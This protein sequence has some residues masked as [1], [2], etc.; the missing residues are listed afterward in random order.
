[1]L[2]QQNST[3]GEQPR[4][5]V[6]LGDMNDTLRQLARMRGLSYS[7]MAALLIRR[8]LNEELEEMR[9]REARRGDAK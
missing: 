6:T 8:A 4:I 3:N 5:H 2:K 1:M 9:Q 7:A